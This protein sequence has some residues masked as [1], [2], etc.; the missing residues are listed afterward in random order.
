MI[1]LE[2]FDKPAQI[3]WAPRTKTSQLGKFEVGGVPYAFSFMQDQPGCYT[4]AFWMDDHYGAERGINDTFGNTKTAK[5]SESLTV[6][7]TAVAVLFTFVKKNK[8]K[9]VTF[10][11]ANYLGKGQMY[12]RMGRLLAAKV[13]EIG[14]TMKSEDHGS[15]TVFTVIPRAPALTPRVNRDPASPAG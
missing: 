9:D 10:S 4:Y 13:E 14:Y 15:D 7:S 8:P 2:L 5:G 1:L 6:L 12:Q 3:N 11:G